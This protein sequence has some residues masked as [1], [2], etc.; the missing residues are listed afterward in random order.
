MVKCED[1]DNSDPI[2]KWLGMVTLGD[3]GVSM[4]FRF[5][6][7]KTVFLRILG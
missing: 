3:E 5:G 7:D 6:R 2:V 4:L 1:G